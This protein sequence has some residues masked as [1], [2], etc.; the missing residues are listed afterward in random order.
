MPDSN[1]TLQ[2]LKQ[3]IAKAVELLQQK[4]DDANITEAR[5]L[6]NNAKEAIA[7]NNFTQ[8]LNLAEKAQLAA[9]PTTEYLLGRAKSLESDGNQAYKKEDFANAIELW[10]KSL[11]EYGR[12][13]ELA[14][15]RDESE[16]VE[17]LT[18]T[19]ASIETDIKTTLI[20]QA[21]KTV[22]EAKEKF[23]AKEFDAVKDKFE[24][25]RQLYEKGA[26][27]AKKLGSKDEAK[28]R[29]MDTEMAAS[30]E[31]CLL[32]KG[33]ALIEQ[34]SGEKGEVKEA[35]FSEAL[36]Y[37]ES[38]SSNSQSYEELKTRVHQGLAMGRIEIGIGL[39][40]DAEGLLDQRQY[41]QAK[42][43]Y[44]KAQEHLESL[45]DFAVEHRLEREKGEVDNLIDDCAANI[46]ACTDSML[47]KRETVARGEIR[48]VED[49]RKGIRLPLRTEGLGDERI[50][51]LKTEYELVRY[52]GGGG[53]G[54][55]Y[56]AK[57]REGVSVAIKV[58][59]EL[60]KYG[61]EIFFRE[62]EIWG[63][64]V[65]RNIVK[66]IRPRIAPIPLFEMEYTE[67]GD[68]GR[69]LQN[70]KVL[71]PERACRIA[72]DISRGLQYAHSSH[73]VIHTDLKPRNILLTN[74]EEAKISDWGLGKIATSSS[75]IKGYTMAYAAPEQIAKGKA[76][77]KTDVY[78]LGAL[79]Y[80]MLTGHNPFAG[81]S[82][83]EM[84]EK[85]L[86]LVPEKPSR[87][88]HD[89][90]IELLDDIVLH[91]LEKEPQERPSIRQ[92][93]ETIYRYMKESH[94]ESLH[95]SEEVNSQR[96]ILC[97]LALLQAKM[98]DYASLLRC[99]EQLKSLIRDKRR[100]GNLQNLM[101]AM[102]F[103]KEQ[104]MEISDEAI[105][106]LNALLRWMEYGQS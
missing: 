106:E 97:N 14:S 72:F 43:G 70:S 75:S 63:R 40:E 57:N 49:L 24:A 68:L 25:A 103:R 74:L 5:Q 96:I 91:C 48:K 65:H 46:K 92:F 8:A 34:A 64:L 80:E 59:R 45:R 44:R 1:Q 41:Y 53:F 22:D 81:G 33:E 37:L 79:F 58:L 99:L 77:E 73:N 31:T 102:A 38:F 56:L 4:H 100:S 86:S 23:D 76:E 51:K 105:D 19:I 9:R 88:T 32:G 50:E 29:E 27:I 2:K 47:G 98:G 87:D 55:V 13:Q 16:I 52:L 20:E 93:K 17:A 30:I 10:Q 104:G 7:K 60:D 3:E 82:V 39:M 85:V 26:T 94:G 36:K 35:A 90:G 42:E 62:L 78:Q 61:E 71:S 89:P 15:K 84:R 11:E 95:L 83:D 69:L 67:G 28:I 101:E 12:A 18:S 6:L 21:N 66:L 54:D